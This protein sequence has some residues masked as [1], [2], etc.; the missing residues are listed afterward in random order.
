MNMRTWILAPACAAC[1]S[2]ISSQ[3]QQKFDIGLFEGDNGAVEVR[4][5][6]HNDFDGIFSSLVF[7]LKWEATANTVIGPLVQSDQARSIIPVAPSGA[8]HAEGA[9][10]YRIYAGNGM[11]NLAAMGTHWVSGQE[12]TIAALPV[13]GHAQVE[14]ANDAWTNDLHHNGDYFISLGGLDRTGTITKAVS[15]GGIPE[16]TVGLLP[17]PN[18]GERLFITIPELADDVDFVTLDITDA[19]GERVFSEALEVNDGRLDTALEM[20]GKLADGLYIVTIGVGTQVFTE[21]L[22]VTK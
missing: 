15:W 20:K 22:V 7:T 2:A 5:V 14:L 1:F 17:N 9:Y 11:E 21:R 16:V 6:P 3:A 19:K 8:V 10:N 4:V 12:Y 18:N 13:A